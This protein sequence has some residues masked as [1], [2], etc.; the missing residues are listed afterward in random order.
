MRVANP[1][2]ILENSELID[3]LRRKGYGELVDCLLDNEDKVY[4]KKGRLN[5]SSTCR[6]MGIK[7]KQL[8]DALM[9]MREILEEDL[10]F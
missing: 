2:D 1:I 7:S 6:E 4:T 5:K 8:E 9:E 10:D 3:K